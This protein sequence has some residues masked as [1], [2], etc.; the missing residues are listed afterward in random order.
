M[1]PKHHPADHDAMVHEHN[2][3]TDTVGDAVM[4]IQDEAYSLGRERG[5]RE[6]NA[7]LLVALQECMADADAYEQ[8]SGKKLVGGWP[9]KARAAI[10]KA[11][12]ATA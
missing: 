12:G 9:E 5:K 7:D 4:R 10:A 3:F 1:T 6:A 8:R 11:T 2:Q